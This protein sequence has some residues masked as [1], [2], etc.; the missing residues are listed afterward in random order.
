MPDDRKQRGG[1]DRNRINVNQDYEVRDWAKKFGVSP[2]EL[3]EAVRAVG[4]RSDK[5]EAHLKSKSNP[6]A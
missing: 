6:S 1:Q 4:D 5:V 2:D 3:K